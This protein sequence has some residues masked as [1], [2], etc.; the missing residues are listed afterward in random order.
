MPTYEYLCTSCQYEFEAFQKMSEEPLT[1][2]PRC[3]GPVRR[4]ISGGSG[5]L[6]KG[7]GFYITDYRSENYKKKASEEKPKTESKEKSENPK[8]VTPPKPSSD[9]P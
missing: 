9:K 6:F 8:P 5:L 1:E 4:K 3:K 7:K 2:C